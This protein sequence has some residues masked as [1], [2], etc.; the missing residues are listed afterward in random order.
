[1]LLW[2]K[3]GRPEDVDWDEPEK[4]HASI[5]FMSIKHAVIT[6]VDRDDLRDGVQYWAETEKLFVE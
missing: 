3:T 2:C 1:V 4:W 5:K 6:S